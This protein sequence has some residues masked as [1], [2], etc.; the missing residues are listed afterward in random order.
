M[1]LNTVPVNLSVL[2]LGMQIVALFCTS[3][4]VESKVLLDPEGRHSVISLSL[5]SEIHLLMAAGGNFAAMFPT[6]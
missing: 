2:K 4:S 1:V 3:G 6:F 5:M